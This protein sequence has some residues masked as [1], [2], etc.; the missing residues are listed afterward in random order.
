MLEQDP[1]KL[2]IRKLFGAF[3]TLHKIQKHF[4]RF[5]VPFLCMRF[6]PEQER[7]TRATGKG[8]G[9]PETIESRSGSLQF[10][11]HLSSL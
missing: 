1:N 7:Q 4:W 6:L 9:S 8:E 10:N 5:F 2:P 11:D 3:L